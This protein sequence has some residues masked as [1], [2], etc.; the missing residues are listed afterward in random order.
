MN[1]SESI[2]ELATALSKFQGMVENATKNSK[3]PFFNSKYADLAEI[4]NTIREPLSQC[5]LS[6]V[7]LPAESQADY[8]TPD[9]GHGFSVHLET[10]LLHSSGEWIS[11]IVSTPVFP[12]RNKKGEVEPVDPQQTTSAITYLRK[13]GLASIVGIAQEDDDGNSASRKTQG[14]EPAPPKAPPA[15][16]KWAPEQDKSFNALMD[17]IKPHYQTMELF[18]ELEKFITDATAWKSKTDP[19][20]LLV[21]LSDHLSKK[22]AEAEEYLKAKGKS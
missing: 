22:K 20:K 1:K 6:V 7:Q 19:G 8:I 3:N 2:K 11:G 4:W 5:G 16:A 17:Q 15:P 21:H 9:T 12:G 18:D 10:I 14:Q 13:T